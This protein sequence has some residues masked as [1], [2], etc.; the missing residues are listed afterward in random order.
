MRFVRQLQAKSARHERIARHIAG[1]R[2]GERPDQREQHGALAEIDH[3][4]IAPDGEPAGVHHE[5]LGLEQRFDAFELERRVFALRDAPRG[6]GVQHAQ[7]A[8]HFGPQRG[9]VRLAR[10]TFGAHQR[11]VG[12]LRTNAPNRDAR[13]H[14]LVRRAQRG[15]QRGR[16]L[17]STHALRRRDG[18]RTTTAAL[19][20]SAHAPRS[21]CRDALR[22][23]RAPRPASSDGKAR[24]REASAT[25][26]CATTQR[27]RAS[28]CFAPNP[29]AAPRSKVFAFTKSP[30]CA[31]AMPRSA[32]AGGSLRSATS[33]SAPSGSPAAS[34]RPAALIKESIEFPTNLSLPPVG[35]PRLG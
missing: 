10:R 22:A 25:S 17:A 2:F 27:A 26:A 3:G 1:P 14:Q 29:R 16:D 9:N 34:E 8:I 23:P 31:I 11:L 15:R 7:R 18:P 20:D 28:G 33:F 19:P 12:F 4:A 32:S 5:C 21:R 6:Q 13:N 24:S 30:S 35:S